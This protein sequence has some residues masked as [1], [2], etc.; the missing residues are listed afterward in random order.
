MITLSY[1]GG[2]GGNWLKRLIINDFAQQKMPGINFHHDNMDPS[3]HI[4]LVH[5][6]DPTKF[7][8]LYSGD[9]YFNFYA[10]VLHKHYVAETNILDQDYRTAFLE[11][12]NTAR[13]I[14]RFDQLRSLVSLDFGDLIH[15]PNKFANQV[16]KIQ[17]LAGFRTVDYDQFVEHRQQFVNTCVDVT[18]MF[19][20]FNNMTWVAFVVGQLMNLDIV[21]GDFK[22]YDV[23]SQDQCRQFAI[24]NYHHCVLKSVCYFD[25]LVTL[26]DLLNKDRFINIL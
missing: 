15:Q 10:N 5:E 17:N 6:L 3:A 14:C 12:V 19:E 11:C 9:F 24:D 8:H 1:P 25:S 7:T 20:N 22:I 21:P 26:D 16:W 13:Y 18:S 4:A 2:S 23:G